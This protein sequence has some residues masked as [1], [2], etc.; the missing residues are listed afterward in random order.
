[1]SQGF[2]GGRRVLVTG[3]TGFKG[4]WL[5][6]WLQL[7]GAEVHGLALE[8]GD[9][10]LARLL[11]LPNDGDQ[12]LGDIRDLDTV[13]VAFARST[14]DV[15]FHLAA[16]S[17]V[18][19]AYSDPVGTYRT[20]VVGTAHVL[21]AARGPDAPRAVV[22]VTSDKVYDP[23]ASTPPFDEQSPLGGADPYS[24]SKAAAEMVAVAYRRA[25][26]AGNGVAVATARAGNVI[27][28]GDWAENRIVPDLLRAR[29]QH[30]PLELRY[31]EAVR[32]WQHVLDPL[33]GYLLLAERLVDDPAGAPEA[34]NF[35]PAAA[36]GCAVSELVERLRAAFGGEPEWRA[37][38]TPELHET[39]DLR[40]SS[41]LA[42]KT[43]GWTPRLEVDDA[44]SWTAEWH[45][46]HERGDD[47][48]GICGAQIATFERLGP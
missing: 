39:A 16:Q 14:P 19:S 1:M 44:I 11:D 18:L 42:T 12:A 17:L 25:Y 37:G 34:L 22:V 43:L 2:W 32:P 40:L 5:T 15:V 6:A 9:P 38:P 31:P 29:E 21:E 4:A 8:A 33:H 45:L 26:L 13:R 3:H 48:H 24:S 35:G 27:G 46:A 28:G 41:Q 36:S 23:S 30:A 47:V 10:S 7:L 20:N